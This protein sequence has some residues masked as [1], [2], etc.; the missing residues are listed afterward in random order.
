MIPLFGKHFTAK[1]QQER[2]AS[3]KTVTHAYMKPTQHQ[4]LGSFL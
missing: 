3:I 2:P 4:L 1:T